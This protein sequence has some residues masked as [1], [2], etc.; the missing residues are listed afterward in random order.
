[1]IINFKL[2]NNCQYR[3]HHRLPGL[4]I[5]LSKNHTSLLIENHIFHAYWLAFLRKVNIGHP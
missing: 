5:L 2:N 3:R 1:M 4:V